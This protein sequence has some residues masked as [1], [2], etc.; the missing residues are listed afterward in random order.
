M[1]GIMN[2]LKKVG[3]IMLSM[4]S[5][6]CS[7][8]EIFNTY[9]SAS[10][11]VSD[12]TKITFSMEV[13]ANNSKRGVT[14]YGEPY[15]LMVFVPY[16]R[17]LKSIA[18]KEVSLSGENGVLRELPNNLKSLVNIDS[19]YEG[20]VVLNFNIDQLEFQSYKLSGELV[21]EQGEE[22]SA[23]P[24]EVLLDT[25]YKEEKINKLWE[26]LMGI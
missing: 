19:S 10:I 13:T 21:V 4:L 22:L 3:I 25:D 6:G 11:T 5:F 2:L 18:L 26:N 1:V 23:H 9:K 7:H 16:V 15:K 8:T 14:V 17:E 24:F 20:S 12:S